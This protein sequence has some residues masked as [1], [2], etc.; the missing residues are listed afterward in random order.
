M[1]CPESRGLE[2]VLC[3]GPPERVPGRRQWQCPVTGPGTQGSLDQ[4]SWFARSSAR[5]SPESLC[6]RKPLSFRQ[7]WTDVKPSFAFPSHSSSSEAMHHFLSGLNRWRVGSNQAWAP[8][9]PDTTGQRKDSTSSLP[10]IAAINAAN[11]HQFWQESSEWWVWGLIHLPCG[12]IPSLI[13]LL[14]VN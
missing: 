9:A 12:L 2:E 5:F 7:V 4:L 3:W 13:V 8:G 1:D 6:P 10:T 11:R 14:S